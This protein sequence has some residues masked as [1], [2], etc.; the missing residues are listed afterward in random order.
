MHLFHV[1]MSVWFSPTSG[2]GRSGA[3]LKPASHSHETT[4]KGR[5]HRPRWVSGPA[6]TVYRDRGVIR[7][8]TGMAPITTA[9]CWEQRGGLRGSEHVS[10]ACVMSG[11]CQHL[12][13]AS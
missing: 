3:G 8:A 9:G 2:D 11:G 6:Q 4:R 10:L 5:S 7:H 13:V 1:T 12:G